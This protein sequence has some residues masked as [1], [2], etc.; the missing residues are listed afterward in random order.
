M[1]ELPPGGQTR[2]AADGLSVFGPAISD[3]GMNAFGGYQLADGTSLV[4]HPRVVL[5][6]SDLTERPIWPVGW[7]DGGYF[8]RLKLP[9]STEHEYVMVEAGEFT[10]LPLRDYSGVN[11]TNCPLPVISITSPGASLVALLPL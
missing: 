4:S 5:V 9:L 2:Y 7:S 10:R 3:L 8:G 11:A 1:D 6:Q